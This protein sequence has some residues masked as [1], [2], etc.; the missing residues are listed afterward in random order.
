MVLGDARS[1][2]QDS[3]LPQSVHPNAKV[4]LVDLTSHIEHLRHV[5]PVLLDRTQ[6]GL[7]LQHAEISPRWIATV[8]LVGMLSLD[9]MENVGVGS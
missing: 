2:W 3:T 7:A 6:R 9:A 5:S 1:V 8:L 4:V